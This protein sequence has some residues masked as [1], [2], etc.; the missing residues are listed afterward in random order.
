MENPISYF[1][2]L[3]EPRMDCCKL[4]SL[5][6]I[7]FL[8]IAAV[9]SGADN[10]VEVEAFGNEKKDWLLKFLKLKNGIPSHDR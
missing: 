6:D 7:I 2:S 3:E 4:H 1:K 9:I 5:E 8:T 10:F